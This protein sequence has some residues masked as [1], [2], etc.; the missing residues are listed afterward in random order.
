MNLS[1]L[2]VGKSDCIADALVRSRHLK[3]LYVISDFANPGLAQKAREVIIEHTNDATAVARHARAIRPDFAII[4]SEEPLA[5]GVVDELRK[6]GIPCVGPTKVLARLESSKAFT[7]ELLSK[8]AIPGNP[9]YRVFRNEEGLADYLTSRQEFVVKPDG[10]TGGKGVKVFG[11]H[12]QSVTEAL[13]YCRELFDIGHEAVVIE[14]KLNGEEFSFQSFYDGTHIAHTIPVQDHKRAFDD[15]SGPN[16]GGM[17]SY[18]CSDHLLPFLSKE[19]LTQAEEINALVGRALFQETGEPYKGILY[20]GF[21]L[22]KDGLRVIEYNARFGD[23]EVMNILSLL[24]TD[25]I[26]ICKSIIDGTLDNLPVTFRNQA[27]V[28]KYIV[29][30]GY[31]NKSAESV[32]S[33]IE[34]SEVLQSEEFGGQLRLYYGAVNQVDGG[35]ELTD[36]RSLA[37]VGIA[38][39]LA[40][41]EVIAEKA[42]SSVKGP[43]FHRRDIGT[44]TLV[45]KRVDHMHA[46]WQ[47]PLQRRIG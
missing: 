40:E 43:V 24:E 35:V 21:M 13:E 45:Q 41:A 32:G 12:F 36:S 26:E 17:G 44:A 15:D 46:V 47:T 33:K 10:L 30:S 20:G 38:D 18:S 16:T 8:Y 3:N 9:E 2:L 11:E 27:S 39:S 7:R 37:F 4:G 25:F 23:P 31:P 34:L 19:Y 1:V 22:T 28:C 5:C 42:A 29:P 6:L 14:E